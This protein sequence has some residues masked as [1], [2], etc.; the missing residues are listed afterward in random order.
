MAT[1]QDA[2][3]LRERA[4]VEPSCGWN[5]APE[6]ERR[7]GGGARHITKRLATRYLAAS[8]WLSGPL[9]GAGPPQ[10]ATRTALRVW[11]DR[12]MARKPAAYKFKLTGG[13]V[14][15]TESARAYVFALM[16]RGGEYVERPVAAEEGATDKEFRQSAIR[17]RG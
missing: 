17:D 16:T 10:R 6:L 12:L 14:S 1:V 8:C 7:Q 4:G 5:A 11:A 13:R 2:K 15:P 9:R 3:R